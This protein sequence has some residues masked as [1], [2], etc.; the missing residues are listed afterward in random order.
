MF[1][2]VHISAFYRI[3]MD[4]I[5]LLPQDRFIL[6]NLWMRSFLP[7]LIFPVIAMGLAEK[8]HTFQ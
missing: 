7:K 5:Q 3:V 8:L 6:N 1:G 4:V 2:P